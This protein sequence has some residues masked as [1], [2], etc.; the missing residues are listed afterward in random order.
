MRKAGFWAIDVKGIADKP[1]FIVINNQKVEFRDAT[2]LW[3]METAEAQRAMLRDLPAR[4]A[5]AISIGP[6]GEKLIK[7]AATFTQGTTYRSFGR[8]G[9]GCVMGSKKLKG[10]AIHGTGKVA[11]GDKKGFEA[12]KRAILESRKKHKK[13]ANWWRLHGSYGDMRQTYELAMQPTRNWQE[14]QFEGWAKLCS[15]TNLEEWP[16][17]NI[18]CAPYCVSPC[19]HYIQIQKGSYQGAH[20]DG[21]EWETVYAFGTECGVDKFDAV[22]AA[23]QICDEHGIDTMS[24]GISIGFAME[25]FEKGLIGKKDTDGVELRFGNDR[26]MIT[27]LKKIVNQ[28]GFGRLLGEGVRRM[29]EEIKGSESF[30]MHVKGMELGGYECR[31]LFGQ[32]LQYAIDARGGCHHGYGLPARV[33]AFNGTGTKIEAKGEFV[34]NMASDR[35]IRDSILICAFV[36]R[37]LYPELLPGIVSSLRGESWSADDLKKVG[38]RIQCQERL[39]NMREGLTREDDSLPARLLNEPKPDGPTKGSVVPLEELKDLYYQA[40]EWD[41]STGHPTDSVLAKLEIEK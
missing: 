26:A 14:G 41:I 11:I 28:E 23:N 19:A 37:V 36:V 22:I 38:W 4:E 3:G 20:C 7:Y 24:A 16:R 2:S 6:A 13:W 40:M 18:S 31:G 34:K 35:T 30:A 27:M 5:A 8:G 10:I 15:E 12:T 39:F 9:A 17:E 29:S 1:T 25:C 33:E 32:A 21:T